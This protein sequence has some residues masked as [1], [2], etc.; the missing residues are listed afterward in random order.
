MG[1]CGEWRRARAIAPQAEETPLHPNVRGERDGF[2]DGEAEKGATDRDTGRET[3]AKSYA[4][5]QRW[6]ETDRTSDTERKTKNRDKWIGLYR[7]PPHPTTKA[8][9]LPEEPLLS[10]MYSQ[11]LWS[12]SY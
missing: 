12:L 2:R 7:A 9:H 6:S 10:A 4:H 1:C 3:E 8:A 5:M 11:C